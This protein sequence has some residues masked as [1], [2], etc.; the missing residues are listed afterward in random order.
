MSF[1]YVILFVLGA[2]SI[3]FGV[4]I[5]NK[6]LKFP[7]L[8]ILFT[9]FLITFIVIQIDANFIVDRPFESAPMYGILYFM[10]AL[11]SALLILVGY[12]FKK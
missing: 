3:A 6:K 11:P 5:A 2:L 12:L 10:Y 7:F 9:P 8:Y 4:F 1:V